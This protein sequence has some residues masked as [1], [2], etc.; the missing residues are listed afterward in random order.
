MLNKLNHGSPNHNIHV[1][2][3]KEPVKQNSF[4]D[5]H[6]SGGAGRALNDILRHLKQFKEFTFKRQ[7]E[8]NRTHYNKTE[9][10]L[11]ALVLDRLLLLIF[12]MVTIT[13]CIIIFVYTTEKD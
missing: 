11:I 12:T 13:M 8:D 9:W 1:R 5:D 6:E 10:Q 7:E 4:N 3:D 2:R